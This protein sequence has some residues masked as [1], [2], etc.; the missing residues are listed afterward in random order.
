MSCVGVKHVKHFFDR[1][2]YLT[3]SIILSIILFVYFYDVFLLG[4]TISTSSFCSGTMPYGPYEC[5]RYV[6]PLPVIDYVASAVQ[7]EPSLMLA[8]DTYKLG[9]VPLWNP[10]IGLGEPFAA[11]IISSVY[12]PLNFI[13]YFASASSYWVIFDLLLLFRLFIAGFFTYCF[14]RE[15]NVSKYGSLASAIAYMA[16]GY[17]IFYINMSHL[18]VEILIPIL[19]FSFEKLI[20]IQTFKYCV[21]SAVL[22]AISIFGGMPESNLFAFSFAGIYYLYRY[23]SE[24]NSERTSIKICMFWLLSTFLLGILLSAILILPFIE[25]LCLSWDLHPSTVGL[26]HLDFSFDTISILIPYLFGSIHNT[27]NGVNHYNILPYIGVSTLFLALCAVS[28]SAKNIRT[29]AFFVI[30]AIFYL[31]KTY[32]LPVVNWIGYLPLFNVSIYPKYCYPEFAFCMAILAG[33][34]LDNITNLDF[35]RLCYQV[36]LISLAIF[37]FLFGNINAISQTFWATSLFDVKVEVVIWVLINALF[38]FIILS[39][40]GIIIYLGFNGRINQKRVTYLMIL[41]LVVELFA[42]VPHFHPDRCDPFQPAPYIQFLENDTEKFRVFG[43]GGVLNPNTAIAHHIFD[44]REFNPMIVDNYMTFITQGNVFKGN[45]Y[46]GGRFTGSESYIDNKSIRTLN[47]I[48]AKYILVPNY[49]IETLSQDKIYFAKYRFDNGFV[50]F[51]HPPAGI[52]Y[53]LLIPNGTTFLNFSVGLSSE[54]WSSDKGDG[55]I[56][57]IL[58][59]ESEDEKKLFSKYVDPKN[60]VD[61][62]RWHNGEIN[63]SEYAGKE[64]N[65]SFVTLPNKNNAWDWAGWHEL[66]LTTSETKI[67]FAEINKSFDLIYD[68]EIKIYENR[69]VFPRSFI[70][71]HAVILRSENDIFNKLNNEDFDLKNV[72]IIEKIPASIKDLTEYNHNSVYTDNSSCHIKDYNMNDVLIMADMKSPGFLIITDT[73]YPGWKVYVD[74][75]EKEILAADYLFRAVFLETGTHSVKFI[76]DPMSYKIGLWITCLTLIVMLGICLIKRKS[77]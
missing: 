14:M 40:L 73:Y 32:G 28:A 4:A 50:L 1:H 48:N 3:I 2:E 35:R 10:Y 74:G 52:N 12:Y 45:V 17:F 49:L 6:G 55:V 68:D 63:L 7:Y 15:L 57:E 43:L 59:V 24:A 26:N 9:I 58:L 25:F 51:E 70:T 5:T 20:K 61:D 41:L 67:D 62:R 11:Q 21:F 77:Q 71:H 44:I 39:A 64:I 56:F 69:N 47:L 29:V 23:Y 13:L 46:T 33:I 53:Q 72:V 66:Y 38:T 8:S 54:V 16:N 22:V 60:K 18:N 76:Y 27:W 65:L 75:V 31:L 37:I 19:L 42:Y 30:F 36:L 34:G